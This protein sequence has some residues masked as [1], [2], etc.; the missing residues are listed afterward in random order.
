MIISVSHINIVI[1]ADREGGRKGKRRTEPRAV[2][3]VVVAAAGDRA[4]HPIGS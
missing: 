1:R 3:Q 4:H 2:R